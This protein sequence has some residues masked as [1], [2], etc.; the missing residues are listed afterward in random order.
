MGTVCS[1][2]VIAKCYDHPKPKAQGLAFFQTRGKSLKVFAVSIKNLLMIKI[3]S[4]KQS[5]IT[6][7][8]MN[9]PALILRNMPQ[10]QNFVEHHNTGETVILVGLG[11]QTLAPKKLFSSF[12]FSVVFQ[13]KNMLK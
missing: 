11:T 3:N 12:V 10:L 9:R 6:V 5:K 1:R 2:R 7:S 4:S 8:Y 13:Q